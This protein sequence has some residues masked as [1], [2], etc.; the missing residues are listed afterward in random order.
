[1]RQVNNNSQAFTLIELPSLRPPKGR[2]WRANAFTLIELLVVIAVIG[3]LAS[4][5]MIA[6]NSARAKARDAQR[7]ANLHQI[8][9]ALRMYFLENNDFPHCGPYNG[10]VWTARS[11][12]SYWNDC[13]TPA[14]SQY[15]AKMPVDPI[16]GNSGGL[17]LY[18]YYI[19][20]AVDASSPCTSAYLN[21]YFE[22]LT[23]NYAAMIINP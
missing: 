22:T 16:N 3:L 10:T 21:I 12:E 23:P 18:Y 5:I 15:I 14:L 20:Y 4:V 19:C 9:I 1:M 8:D 17:S 2:L 11:T 7:R 6:L 13:M